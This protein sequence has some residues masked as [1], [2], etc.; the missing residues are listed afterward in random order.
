MHLYQVGQFIY[1]RGSQWVSYI[2]SKLPSR[3]QILGAFAVS[4]IVKVA[5]DRLR[6]RDSTNGVGLKSEPKIPA[7]TQEMRTVVQRVNNFSSMMYQQ[8]A[9]V[10]KDKNFLFLSPNL[11]AILSLIYAVA[12]APLKQTFAKEFHIDDQF[13][14]EMLHQG[15][16]RYNNSLEDRA[17]KTKEQNQGLLSTFVQTVQKVRKKSTE[18]IYQVAHAVAL[19]T[20][21]IA[22]EE[23][24][25]KVAFY[26][27]EAIVFTSA[28]EAEQK[29]NAWIEQKT[30]GKIKDLVK[31]LNPETVCIFITTSI[32]GGQWVY[33]F[34]ARET[35]RKNFYNFDGSISSVETMSRGTDEIRHDVFSS[36]SLSSRFDILE[37]PFHGQVSMVIARPIRPRDYVGFVGLFSYENYIN[38]LMEEGNFQELMDFI[39]SP[40]FKKRKALIIEVPKFTSEDETDLL[41]DFENWE[42]MKSVKGANFNGS[43]VTVKNNPRPIRVDKIVSRTLF[44]MDENGVEIAAAAYSPTGLQSCDPECKINSPFLYFF[45]DQKTQ[46]VFGCGRVLKLEGSEGQPFKRY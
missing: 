12:P 22:N 11:L 3:Y 25:R 41:K 37:L 8:Y 13:T 29:A 9:S 10:K 4:A 31:N 17:E 39:A 32:F 1:S 20:D 26:Q 35:Q 43:L 27:P 46:T 16:Q 2:V 19:R 42:L 6:S 45:Y 36:G 44:K 21:T 28:E 40:N 38:S 24:F 7:M 14:E 5:I 15:L 30:E 34:N 23:A 33:P 18:L